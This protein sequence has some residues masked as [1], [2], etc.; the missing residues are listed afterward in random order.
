MTAGT[1]RTDLHSLRYGQPW[2]EDAARPALLPQ[3]DRDG[4]AVDLV[5]H[6]G[7]GLAEKVP[8][9]GFPLRGVRLPRSPHPLGCRGSGRGTVGSNPIWTAIIPIANQ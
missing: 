1:G 7:R 2:H 5:G 8:Q 6:A 9:L 4:S 3:R